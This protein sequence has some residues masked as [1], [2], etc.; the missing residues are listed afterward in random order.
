MESSEK[1][2][3]INC[4]SSLAKFCM[5]LE[6]ESAETTIIRDGKIVNIALTFEIDDIKAQ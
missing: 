5:D 1:M 6:A 2:M 3:V 4:A